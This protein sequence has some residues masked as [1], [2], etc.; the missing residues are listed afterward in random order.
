MEP[1][2]LL[3]LV[4]LLMAATVVL[5]VA[6]GH[7]RVPPAVAFVVGGM[8]LGLTPGLRPI[9]LD[10]ALSMLLFL[11]PLLQSS[12]FFTPWRDFRANLG[13]ILLLAVGAVVFTTIVVGIALKLLMPSLPWAA[14]F[15]L[16]AIVSPPDAVSA[17]AVLERLRLPRRLLS[18]LEGE[19]LVN[20]A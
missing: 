1:V 11:P 2:G 19:S 4:L 16:G 9:Q 6:A 7:L 12:A 10:P 8:A 14:C 3:E 20:D 18:V 17:G 5:A 13:S 15:T